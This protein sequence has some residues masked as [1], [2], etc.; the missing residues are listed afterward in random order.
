MYDVLEGVKVIEVAGWVMVPSAG[1]ILGDWGADVIKVEHPVTGDSYRGL[2]NAAVGDVG[3]KPLLEIAN[4]GKRSIG[5]DVTTPQGRD[6]LCELVEQADVFTTSLTAGARARFQLDFDDMRKVNDKIV[7]ACGTGY[8]SRGPDAGRPGFDGAATWA[9]AGLGFRMTPPDADAPAGQPGSVG[10]LTGGLSLAAGIA[11]ALFRRERTGEAQRVEASLY[12]VGM[13]LM[14]Q[15]ITAA[16]HGLSHTI[17]S[18]VWRERSSGPRDERGL[19]L[20]PLV[21]PYR[22]SDG[23]WL[24]LAMLKPDPDWPDFCAHIGRS[25][26]IDDPRFRNFD[27]RREHYWECVDILREVFAARPLDRW[28]KDL[29]TFRGVW[30]AFLSPEEIAEDPQA[31]ENGY[32]SE[33]ETYDGAAFRAVMSPVQFEGRPIGGG[34]RAMPDAGQHTEEILLEMGKDWEQII[35][36]KDAA[37]IN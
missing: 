26:L 7:Y 34:L 3:V 21:G 16:P 27:A 32:F 9:R 25:D 24:T 36:Y 28:R 35:A 12:H 30:D 29:S 6:L 37:V 14:C 23:R 4:R 19:T 2:R 33:V 13:Y 18:G 10:D 8:G 31:L 1:L 5:L 22:T 11:A 15:S 20:N 17:G